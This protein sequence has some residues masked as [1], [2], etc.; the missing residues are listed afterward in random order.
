L[1][2]ESFYPLGFFRV[3][4]HLSLDARCLIYPRP[5][6]EPFPPLTEAEAQQ[7]DDPKSTE[8]AADFAGFRRRTPADS[9]KHV[10]WKQA[11]KDESRPLLVAHLEGGQSG[12]RR[13]AW[14]QTATLAR[15][16]ETR[17]SILTGWVLQAA[18]ANLAWSLSLPQEEIAQGTGPAHRQRCLEALAL[19][20][21]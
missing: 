14:A 6:F 12:E 3:W 8:G 20:S 2:I 9:M 4:Q 11:A 7:V 19:A 1:L 13:F 18:Q 21:P 15:D 16:T 17:F 10:A 5:I